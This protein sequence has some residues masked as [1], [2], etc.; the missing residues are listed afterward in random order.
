MT[1]DEFDLMSDHYKVQYLYDWCE[2]Q[3]RAISQLL[4]K[5][6]VLEKQAK[7]PEQAGR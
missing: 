2:G 3:D 6:E 1:K 5:I 7:S 4:A